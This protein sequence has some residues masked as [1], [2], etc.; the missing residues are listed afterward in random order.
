M[1]PDPP[2]PGDDA[3]PA[4]AG[5]APG[6]FTELQARRLGPLRRFLVRH[7]RVMD[8]V[9]VVVFLVLALLSVLTT[10]GM[11]LDSGLLADDDRAVG[12]LLACGVGTSV[13]A[14][15]SLVWRR[16]APVVVTAALA[17]LAV[18]SLLVS[19][20][21]GA[22]DLALAC[23]LYA[24]AASRPPRTAWLTFGGTML[25]VAGAGWVW[26][27][28]DL[29]NPDITVIT[30][31][32]PGGVAP[33]LSTTP[34][35]SHVLSTTGLL[36]VLLIALSIGTSVRNRRLHVADLVER[37]N[38][39]ARDRDQQARLARAAERTRIAREMHD[40]VAHS[41]TVMVALSD[42]AS[43]ALNRSPDAARTAL[44]ELSS[45]GRGALA[46]MRRVLGVLDGHDAPL[47]PQP[48]QDDLTG[49]V[50]RFRAAGLPVHARG[51]GTPLPEET[52]FRLA[53]HRIVA[54]ALTNALRHAPGTT[55]VLVDLR[56]TDRAVEVE[57][58]DEG[59]SLPVADA[60]GAGRGLIG[61][62]ERAA[63]YG[64]TVD[65]GPTVRGGWR[66]H[67]ILPC[68]APTHTDA[69]PTAGTDPGTAPDPEEIPA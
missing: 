5:V 26:E 9:V 54:E 46:D 53:V 63:V 66:V 18:A 11:V 19:G 3:R 32:D 65:A 47:E 41:I 69:R 20:T 60:G 2:T 30:P 12:L 59:T 28:T 40:V 56:R 27:R 15:A 67:V 42:G 17:V 34:W 33:V 62:R 45:T 14:A 38:A 6:A 1:T 35:Q 36:V 52:T 39:L 8:A 43:A 50:E 16:A 61:M 49:V 58:V 21:L 51:L 68:D 44:D 64:G 4:G 22:L 48:G 29:T 7:P 23:G 13:L 31:E 37:T 57:V 25:V 24:V 55:R 10:T